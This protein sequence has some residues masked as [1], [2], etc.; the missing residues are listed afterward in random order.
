MRPE[1]D[2]SEGRDLR[3]IA[4]LKMLQSLV[5]KLNRL[6]DVNEIGWARHVEQLRMDRDAAGFF[7]AQMVGD[8]A[9]DHNGLSA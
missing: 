9:A 7:L 6:N 4:H 8:H 2:A 1:G 5:G 3:S